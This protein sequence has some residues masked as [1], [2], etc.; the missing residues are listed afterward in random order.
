MDLLSDVKKLYIDYINNVVVNK[1]FSHAYLIELDNYDSDMKYVYIFIKM[2]ICNISYDDLL[3]SDN[4]LMMVIIL[5]LLLFLQILLSLK[6][7]Q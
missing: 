2:L 4:I 6:S 5:I 7:L 1:K 3:K